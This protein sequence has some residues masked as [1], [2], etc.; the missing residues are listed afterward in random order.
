MDQNGSGGDA[1]NFDWDT[2]DEL[3]IDNYAIASRSGVS[4]TNGEAVLGTAEVSSS[5]DSP[6]SK[7]IDHFVGMGF[8]Q[9]LVTK[10]IEEN[11]KLVG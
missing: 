5:A 6:N 4:L 3:E 9:E 2:E 11:G 8:S 7:L 10:A 1:D